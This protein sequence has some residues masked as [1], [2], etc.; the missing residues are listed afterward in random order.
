MKYD[1]LSFV[2][3]KIYTFLS[4]QER[5][6]DIKNVLL[7][8]AGRMLKEIQEG[9]VLFTVYKCCSLIMN[10]EPVNFDISPNIKKKEVIHILHE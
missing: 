10:M 5:K 9:N 6:K 8:S 2:C 3:Q 7:S 1:S 4:Y